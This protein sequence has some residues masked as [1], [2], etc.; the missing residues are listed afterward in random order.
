VRRTSIAPCSTESRS[1]QRE[2]GVEARQRG[3]NFPC[4]VP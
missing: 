1:R 2:P 4:E 3:P